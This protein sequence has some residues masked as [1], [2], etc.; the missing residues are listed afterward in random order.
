[1]NHHT[2][3]EIS[4]LKNNK[5]PG[6]D[7][8]PA[9]LFKCGGQELLNVLEEFPLSVWMTERLP[10]EWSE[11]IICPIHKKG[12]QLDCGNYR[13]ISLL[14]KILP[15]VL[16]KRLLPYLEAVLR[17]YQCSFS[18]GKSTIDKIFRLRM[19]LEKVREYQLY[20]YHLFI[21]IKAAYGNVNRCELCKAMKK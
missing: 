9:Q 19:I 16:L 13:G 20:K 18:K 14:D 4:W 6:M 2:K 21:D 15:N 17:Q 11:T 12:D 10:K 1:M 3:E 7:G 8:V 5:A